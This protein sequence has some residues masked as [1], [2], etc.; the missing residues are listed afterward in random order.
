MFVQ[1]GNEAFN[2]DLVSLVNF[3]P[4]PDEKGLVVNIYLAGDPNDPIILIDD[5]ADRFLA[6]W[7]SKADVCVL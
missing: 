5:D 4:G 7:D 2:P 6:W 1:I 3:G